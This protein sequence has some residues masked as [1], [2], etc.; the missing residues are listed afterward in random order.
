MA[1]ALDSWW[2]EMGRPDPFVVVEAGAGSG[3]LARAVA[4]AAPACSPA[5]RYVLVERSEALREQQAG[6][7]PLEPPHWA[8]GPTEHEED[9]VRPMAGVGP[10]FTS[11]ADMPAQPFT[12]VVL[13]NEL[14]DDLP[15]ILLERTTDGW[16]EVRVTHDGERFA[17][18]LV[19]AAPELA[20]EA[21]RLAPDAPV[22][23]RIP[24][25]HAARDWLRRVLT[26]VERGRV[27]VVDYADATPSMARRPWQEWLRTYRA[28]GRG[29]H[30]LE[31]PGSQDITCEVAVDQLA[32]V[33]TPAADRSQAEF[34]RAHGIEA[35]AAEARA[36]WQERAHIG[37]L[38]AVRWRSRASEADAL[39]DPAGL[40]AFRVLEW[41]VP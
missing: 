22:A 33:R 10:L 27:V 9:E 8:I 23:G 3:A 38:E 1:R 17:E 26:V 5:L 25:Q 2:E 19:P 40:G 34:L 24:L 7:V 11:L 12:G 35:L 20:E 39:L 41:R 31:A 28:H 15:P 16:A 6:T 29:A 14:L 30:P 37:D 18:L 13:A 21:V 4:D 36:R 32:R